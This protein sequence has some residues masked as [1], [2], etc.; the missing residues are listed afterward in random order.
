[1]CVVS[2]TT[3]L[4]TLTTTGHIPSRSLKKFTNSTTYR[5]HF[6]EILNSYLNAIGCYTD[7]KSHSEVGLH[8]Q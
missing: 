8:I 7:G 2:D 6:F 1:M 4:P 3:N 5:I